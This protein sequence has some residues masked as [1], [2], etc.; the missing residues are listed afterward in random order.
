MA[1]NKDFVLDRAI[2]VGGS[3]KLTIG[4]ISSS[5][6]DLSSGNYFTDTLTADTTYTFSNAGTVQY[7]Q[8]EVTGNQTVVG[9]DLANA[10]Y[11]SVSFSVSLYDPT[12]YSIQFKPD[13]TKFY[14]I[15]N[16]SG[17]KIQQFSLSTAWDLST[18]SSDSKSYT[19]GFTT[20]TCFAIKPDGTQLYVQDY[21]NATVYEYDINTAWDISTVNS[22]STASYTT[23]GEQAGELRFKPDGTK[24]YLIA[25]GTDSITQYSLS[26]AWDLSTASTDSATLDVSTQETGPVAMAFNDDGTLVFVTGFTGSEI[27]QYSLS[28]AWDISTA[29]YDSVSFDTTTPEANLSSLFFSSDGTKMYAMSFNSDSIYQFSTDS[30]SVNTITWPT[31]VDW[32]G[33]TASSAPDSGVT[34]IYSFVTDDG[35]TSYFGN[36][37]ITYE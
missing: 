2:E 35:G 27:H 4:S 28:T 10:S 6:I 31:S 20:N 15:G 11:D 7:F 30:T 19:T 36:V 33:G 5:D 25:N 22:T 29:S 12:P 9:F 21:A 34:A 14:M 37:G 23:T 1:N 24:F 26:T 8:V 32:S 17:G 3:T 13:G 18:A 16:S